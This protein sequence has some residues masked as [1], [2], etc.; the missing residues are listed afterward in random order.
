LTSSGAILSLTPTQTAAGAREEGGEAEATL[1]HGGTGVDQTLRLRA[2]ESPEVA[3]E[4]LGA[5][6]QVL[7]V[8][9]KT[10]GSAAAFRPKG[11]GNVARRRPAASFL[12][13]PETAA[14]IPLT[15]APSLVAVGVVTIRKALT[16]GQ[17]L[18]AA[19]GTQEAPVAGVA[20]V[21]G[22]PTAHALRQTPAVR[23]TPTRAVAPHLLVL[24]RSNRSWNGAQTVCVYATNKAPLAMTVKVKVAQLKRLRL[25]VHQKKK[26]KKEA[27][28]KTTRPVRRRR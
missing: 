11:E 6:D 10:I 3:L 13:H 17:D 18:M 27:R 8:T 28:A 5:G 23:T 20:A 24:S 19:V 9:T 25:M 15:L 21:G 16:V 2:G 26:K 4:A 1:C 14:T 7:A 12:P 22:A